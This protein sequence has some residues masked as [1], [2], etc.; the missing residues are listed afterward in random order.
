MT[1]L[2]TFFSTGMTS[3]RG[4]PTVRHMERKYSRGDLRSQKR[5]R[6]TKSV[7]WWGK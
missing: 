3:S 7:L 2:A 5:S 6:S 1:N 4:T